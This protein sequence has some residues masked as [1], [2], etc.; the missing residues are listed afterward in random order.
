VTDDNRVPGL[1]RILGSGVPGDAIAFYGRWWQLETWLREMVYVE[2]RSRFGAVWADELDRVAHTRVA[3]EERNFYMSSA[4][5]EELLAYADVSALFGIIEA[6]WG[7][8]ETLLPPRRRWEGVTDELR[9]LRN[10]NAHCRRPHQDDLS[11][12]EQTLRDLEAGAWRFYTSYLNTRRVPKSKDPLVRSW[13]TGR[14]EAA[15]RLIDHARRQYETR[16]ELSYSMRPWATKPSA[17]QLAGTPGLLWHAHWIIGGRDLNVAQLWRRI[18]HSRA[19]RELIVH[20]LFDISTVTVT[21]AAVD[22]PDAIADAIGAIFDAILTESRPARPDVNPKT[23]G[24]SWTR[25]A[26][27][28]PRCVQVNTPLTIVDPY[29]PNAFSLFSA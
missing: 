13:V 28:L 29:Q 2:L 25:G 17:G 19:E 4:D 11:R 16:F 22:D 8:F 5:S 14:H 24:E 7:L 15:A 23:W 27:L 20:L 1:D 26:E 9:E 10:R 6:H 12:L 21:F 18:E 3:G